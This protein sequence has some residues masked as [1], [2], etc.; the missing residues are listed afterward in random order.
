VTICNPTTTTILQYVPCGMLNGYMNIR[1]QY[2]INRL[3]YTSLN[4]DKF[5]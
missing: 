2:L 5:P 1:E 3:S 4:Q